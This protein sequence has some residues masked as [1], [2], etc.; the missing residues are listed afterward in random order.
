VSELGTVD[1]LFVSDLAMNATAFCSLVSGNTNLVEIEIGAPG[2][3]RNPRN[4]SNQGIATRRR[5]R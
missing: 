4:S 2:A 5:F 1:L 3:R